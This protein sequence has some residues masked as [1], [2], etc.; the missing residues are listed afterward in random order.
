MHKGK[1]DNWGLRGAYVFTGYR[2]SCL[3]T[4]QN[5]DDIALAEWIYASPYYTPL[6][7]IRVIPYYFE[8]SFTDA[9]L[10]LNPTMALWRYRKDI[11]HSEG[12]TPKV[13]C[14]LHV[15]SGDSFQGAIIFNVDG[16][17][18][19]DCFLKLVEC[20]RFGKP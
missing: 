5:N 7:F 18:E 16:E 15:D 3:S 6:T 14:V 1:E 4:V 19:R 8:P 12:T 17:A 9:V 2:S 20:S 11:I 13:K 10:G